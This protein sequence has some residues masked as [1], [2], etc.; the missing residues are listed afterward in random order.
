MSDEQPANQH[1]YP[2][3]QT[4][5]SANTDTSAIQFMIDQ[6]I[7]RISGAQLVK[8]TKV[9]TQGEVGPVGKVSVQVLT[10]V[11]DG[12]RNTFSHGA[13][14][15]IPFFRLQGG[16]GKAVIMDPKVGDIGIAVFADRDISGVKR[17]KKESPPGSFRKHDMADG[18]YIGGFLGETP[19][20]YIRFTDDDKIIASPDAGTTT[21]TIEKNKVKAVAGALE[22]VLKPDFIF[23]GKE[24]EG[25]FVQT[26]AGPSSV[27][28]AKV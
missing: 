10:K 12:Q 27:V 13:I 24:N 16:S 21:L 26:V 22:V 7:A 19:S 1:G 18:L 14:H 6:A 11:M 15:N 5:F 9:S 28:K 23:L 25:E 8:I 20:C 17:T 3:Q 2:M 4:P